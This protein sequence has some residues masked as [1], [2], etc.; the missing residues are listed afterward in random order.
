MP[1]STATQVPLGQP[2]DRAD[3]I[4][5]H[6]RATDERSGPGSSQTTRLGQRGRRERARAPSCRRGGRELD[7]VGHVL[8]GVVADAEAAAEIDDAGLPAELVAALGGERG[9]APDRLGLR[10]EVGELRADVDVQAQDV[11]AARESHPHT[12]AFASAGGSPNF[13]P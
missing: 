4:E 9:Q 13:E 6:A 5:R 7:R 3:A 11:E 8:V 12:A 2:L 10:G 1:P